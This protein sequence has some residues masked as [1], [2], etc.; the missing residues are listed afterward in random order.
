RRRCQNCNDNGH[1]E[2][3]Y[4]DSS[5]NSSTRQKLEQQESINSDEAESRSTLALISNAVGLYVSMRY[6]TT[7][8]EKT[9]FKECYVTDR[10]INPVDLD[11]IDELNL[12]QFPDEKETCQTPTL[13]PTNAENLARELQRRERNDQDIIPHVPPRL[14]GISLVPRSISRQRPTDDQIYERACNI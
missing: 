3:F 11:W 5:T 2:V 9:I 13:E 10:N 1:K 4:Q 14:D 7:F 6:E 12:I 8:L